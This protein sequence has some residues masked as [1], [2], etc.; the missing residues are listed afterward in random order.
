MGLTQ[1]V[2]TPP[3]PVCAL[4]DRQRTLTP[5]GPD[6]TAAGR[7]SASSSTPPIGGSS[8][9]G[10]LPVPEYVGQLGPLQEEPGREGRQMLSLASRLSQQALSEI[11]EK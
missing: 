1:H 4:L 6:F 7:I 3:H 8:S 2:F 11:K 9:G 10:G 5:G